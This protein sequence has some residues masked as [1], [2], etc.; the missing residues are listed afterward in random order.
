MKLTIK[1]IRKMSIEE[2]DNLINDDNPTPE[3]IDIIYSRLCKLD[4][5]T[6]D[7]DPHLCCPNWPNCDI[8]GCGG[9]SDYED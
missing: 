6:Y 8:A 9:D 3:E 2:L 7:V 4:P 5:D 1:Q